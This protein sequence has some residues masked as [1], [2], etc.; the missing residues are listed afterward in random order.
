MAVARLI[1]DLV[2]GTATSNVVSL[3]CLEPVSST[4]EPDVRFAGLSRCSLDALAG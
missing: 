3:R 2:E 1:S 4:N